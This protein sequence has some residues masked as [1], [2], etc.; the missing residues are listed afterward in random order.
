MR[1]TWKEGWVPSQDDHLRSHSQV[2]LVSLDGHLVWNEQCMIERKSRRFSNSKVMRPKTIASEHVD[3][4]G[5]MMSIDC[6]PLSWRTSFRWLPV[7]PEHRDLKGSQF[8][9]E[10]ILTETFDEGSIAIEIKPVIVR[11]T[12]LE[13]RGCARVPRRVI[14][15]N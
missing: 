3:W 5:S 6:Q 2:H 4:C 13:N 12:P 14:R 1:G 10:L 11:W 15:L 9:K 8:L 7:T